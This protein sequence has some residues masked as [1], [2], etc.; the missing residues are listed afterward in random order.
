MESKVAQPSV[1][2]LSGGFSQR[3]IVPQA[4]RSQ[5]IAGWASGHTGL[6]FYM[7]A[8]LLSLPGQYSEVVSISGGGVEYERR[9]SP[10]CS[11]PYLVVGGIGRRGW[12]CVMMWWAT[13]CG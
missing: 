6:S 12:R 4:A 11:A 2:W 3:Q 5:P 8:Y 13:E 7:C 9:H 10:T 1:S